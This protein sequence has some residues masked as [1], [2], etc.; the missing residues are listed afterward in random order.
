VRAPPKPSLV[1][2]AR[3]I[4]EFTALNCHVWA[5]QQAP[6]GR[7]R[8]AVHSGVPDVIGF[9]PRGQFIGVEI[10]AGEDTLHEDQW[11]FLDGLWRSGGFSAV[12]RSESSLLRLVER[13]KASHWHPSDLALAWPEQRSDEWSRMRKAA[14][15]SLTDQGL[16][17]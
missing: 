6:L 9:S 11:V 12:V 17:I 8:Y 10:K 7:R 15:E 16:G 5:Q 1:L 4:E 13:V 2:R 14:R 3:T